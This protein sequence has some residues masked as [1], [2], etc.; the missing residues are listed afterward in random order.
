MASAC[1]ADVLLAEQ[2]IIVDKHNALRRQ[3]AKGLE[4]RGNPGPQ[5]PASNMRQ[6]V[7]NADL[8]KAAQEI[9]DGGYFGE[10]MEWKPAGNK[11][12]LHSFTLFQL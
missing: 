11:I 4:K 1:Y 6:M 2:K 12:T 9:A 8:A 10:S 5:P 7:W 3:V